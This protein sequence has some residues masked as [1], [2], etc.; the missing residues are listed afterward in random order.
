MIIGSHTTG[1]ASGYAWMFVKPNISPPKPMMDSPTEKKSA[2]AALSDSPKLC[3]PNTASRIEMQ[4]MTVSVR[5][6]ALQPFISVCSPPSVGPIAGA[7][8]IAMPTMPIAMPRLSSGKIENTVIC[9]TGHM[10]P[11]PTASRKR[12]NSAS[13]NVGLS[14]ASTEPTVNTT[15]E[16]MTIWRVE[17]RRVRYAVSG[18]ITPIVSW[19][20]DVIHWPSVTEMPKSSTSD[21]RAALSCSCVKL[22]TKVM[23][24]RMASEMNAG[25]VRW[26]LRY[27]ISPV[28]TVD[29]PAMRPSCSTV[30]GLWCTSRV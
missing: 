19:K 11:V 5:K 26:S 2:C 13:G 16:A 12:P 17:N 7:T 21:G 10:T 8:A 30:S 24:V 18:T 3:N 23:N 15:I 9:R 25:R 14:H 1:A 29:R 28:S 27:D 6:M 22:P 4:P 20:I